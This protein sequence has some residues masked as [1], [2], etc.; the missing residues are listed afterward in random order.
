[1]PYGSE[2]V[3]YAARAMAYRAGTRAMAGGA[4]RGAAR[5]P[6]YKLP[7]WL[8]AANVAAGWKQSRSIRARL[9]S[10]RKAVNK[11]MFSKRRSNKLTAKR[12]RR[13]APKPPTNPASKLG[14]AYAIAPTMRKFKKAVATK[15]QKVPKTCSMHYKEYGQFNADKCM[16]INHEHWGS[17][18]KFWYMIAVALTKKLC[19]FAKLYPGKSYEDPMIGPRTDPTGQMQNQSDALS[20]GGSANL[21]LTFAVQIPLTGETNFANVDITLEN[22]AGAGVDAYRSLDAIAKDVALQMINQYHASDVNDSPRYLKSAQILQKEPA[23]SLKSTVQPIF[24]QNLDDA[25][26]CLYATTLLKFQNITE[27]DHPAN[28]TSEG[29]EIANG[30]PFSRNAID[31]N[32]LEGRVFTAK[33]QH[34]PVDIDLVQS[35]DGSLDTFFGALDNDGITL[36]GRPS[37]SAT[38]QFPVTANDLGRIKHIPHAKELYAKTSVK[39]G[40]IYMGAGAMKYHKT[41][42]TMKRTFR[43]LHDVVENGVAVGTSGLTRNHAFKSDFGAH[44]L[45]GLTPQHKHGRDTIKVGW[46]RE[47]NYSGMIK[48][49]TKVHP[50]KTNFSKD[51]GSITMTISPTEIQM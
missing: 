43:T 3:P 16:Y 9:G 17:M 23:G 51:K 22:T 44:T 15:K 49:N 20:N 40:T 36:L 31:A 19:A 29:T 28:T 26:I 37:I 10:Y 38:T 7:S 47:I 18:D 2:L 32:P 50:V 33:G 14:G 27:A 39:A 4:A 24:I 11:T 42:F 30:D 6:R 21:R 41:Y 46:N 48:L 45:F 12:Q 25:E 5:R 13:A 1:M 35:G 8:T 34:M